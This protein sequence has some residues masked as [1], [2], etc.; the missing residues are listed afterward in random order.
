MHLSRYL[1]IFYTMRRINSSIHFYTVLF[2][3]LIGIAGAAQVKTPQQDIRDDADSNFSALAKKYAQHKKIPAEYEKQIVYTLSYF[4]ELA[5]AKINFRIKKSN[6]GII[7]TRP[8]LGGLLRSS[9]KRR[10][11]VTIYDS[12]AGRRFP[13]F[14]NGP[15]N[16]QV[17]I[18]GH[19]LCHIL[20]FNNRTGLGLVSLGIAHISTSYMDRFENRTDSMD[21]ERGL[22]Y[23]L[24][25]WKTYLDKYFGA[26]TQ[27][28]LPAF[29]KSPTR[30]RYMSVE[31][32]RE[33]M[34]R[35][36]VYS[37]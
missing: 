9:S 33:V 4:P 17:G 15:F 10:Y 5:T 23:Q 22:G 28:E 24:I 32:I 16:G 25:S 13:S 14:A 1:P 3:L 34:A 30:E 18:L 12:A 19:E 2:F 36:K 8:T 37:R 27:S 21:I 6:G 31:R 29:A 7:S 11:I 20:F 35:S 26:A